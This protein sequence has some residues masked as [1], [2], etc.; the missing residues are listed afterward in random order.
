MVEQFFYH[1]LK[2]IANNL[3]TN[4]ISKCE[5]SGYLRISELTEEV[6]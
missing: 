5:V 2:N 6:R 3:P 1:W 4:V